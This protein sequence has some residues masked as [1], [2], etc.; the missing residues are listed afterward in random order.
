MDKH[1]QEWIIYG[2]WYNTYISKKLHGNL[3][4]GFIR[5]SRTDRYNILY[6]IDAHEKE[7][8]YFFGWQQWWGLSTNIKFN[9]RSIGFSRWNHRFHRLLDK[10]FRTQFYIILSYVCFYMK[11]MFQKIPVELTKEPSPRKK[12]KSLLHAIGVG[13]YVK[14]LGQKL[15]QLTKR[16]LIKKFQK[17]EDEIKRKLTK[18]N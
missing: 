3:F 7:H 8:T 2:P 15:P 12:R 5:N 6:S 16:R 9:N 14:I 17:E 4:E 10:S 13:W 1:K 18:A 11:K